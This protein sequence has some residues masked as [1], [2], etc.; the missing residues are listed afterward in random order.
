MAQI[1]LGIGTSHGPM[2][3]TETETWEARVPADKVNRHAWKGQSWSYDELVQARADEQLAEQVTR[4]VW[5]ERQAVCQRNIERLADVF[6]EAR[7]DVAVV[8]GNDQMELFDNSLNPAFGVHYG[9]TITNHEFSEERLKRLPPGIEISLPGYIPSGGADY[10]GCPE[11]G[12]HIIK[13]AIADEFDVAAMNK[14]PKV[15]KPH[16]TGRCQ[17]SW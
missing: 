11:L 10:R 8:V 5:D 13:Q 12:L 4:S 2:L 6:E 1:V 14:L 7:V 15:E 16:A 17:A 9:D 3:V